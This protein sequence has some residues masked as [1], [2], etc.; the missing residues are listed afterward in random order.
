MSW[1]LFGSLPIGVH[2][3]QG[4]PGTILWQKRVHIGKGDLRVVECKVRG[5]CVTDAQ[6]KKWLYV[7]FVLYAIV[8]QQLLYS[9]QNKDS[10][11]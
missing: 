6:R 9:M 5:T 11:D 8:K 3:E 7:V 2:Q 10:R 4:H 1:L